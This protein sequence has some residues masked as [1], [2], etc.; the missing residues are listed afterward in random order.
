MEQR[1]VHIT[2]IIQEVD[3]KE[4]STKKEDI[5]MNNSQKEKIIFIEQTFR[6]KTHLKELPRKMKNDIIK[7]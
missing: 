4:A 6:E 2:I 1:E 7:I 5:E 3:S